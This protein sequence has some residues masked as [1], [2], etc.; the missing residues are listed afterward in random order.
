MASVDIHSTRKVSNTLHHTDIFPFAATRRGSRRSSSAATRRAP[1]GR[2]ELDIPLFWEE[3][4]LALLDGSKAGED[5]ETLRDAL[6]D[7]CA[8]LARAGWSAAA[9]GPLPP[10]SLAPAM[11]EWAVATVRARAVRL[12]GL[13]G[14]LAL[15]PGVDCA[16]HAP[17]G[18]GG[19]QLVYEGLFREPRV[20]LAAARGE[21]GI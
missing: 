2:S 11:Y 9:G 10:A 16:A 8:Q 17:G 20:R 15:A 19:P 21:C 18:G 7:E 13:P 14:G 4:E 3:D 12:P 5:T 1:P 6:A